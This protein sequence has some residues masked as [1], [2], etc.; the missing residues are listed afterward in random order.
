MKDQLK[1][2]NERTLR[3]YCSENNISNPALLVK[4][5]IDENNTVLLSELK[6]RD[7]VVI[8]K[9]TSERTKKQGRKAAAVEAREYLKTVKKSDITNLTKAK[10]M[11]WHLKAILKRE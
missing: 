4:S 11:L 6:D 10:D 2:L 9:N 3:E 1:A 5:I 8:A 7:S